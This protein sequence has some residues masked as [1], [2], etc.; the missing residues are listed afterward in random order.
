MKL[1]VA[2]VLNRVLSLTTNDSPRYQRRGRVPTHKVRKYRPAILAGFG[3]FLALSAYADTVALTFVG[4]GTGVT[5]GADYVLPYQL[6]VNGVLVNAICYDVFDEVTAG[7]TWTANELTLDQAAVAGQFHAGPNALAEYKEIG[8]L[9]RQVTASPQNQID[10]Q[11]DIWN[12]F[13]PGRYAVTAGMQSYLNLLATSAFT[14]FDF[15]SVRFLEDINQGSG[16][17]QAFV[18]DPPP[19]VPEP[20]TVMLFGGG[21]LLVF[22]VKFRNSRAC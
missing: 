14:S 10:L 8:F 12:V 18:I 11:Q 5:N 4:A 1:A 3:L 19:S 9:S 7:Q 22:A 2:S 20:G 16:R 6:T 15:G 17:A 13:A 21:M